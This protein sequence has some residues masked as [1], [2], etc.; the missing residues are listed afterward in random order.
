MSPRNQS[1]VIKLKVNLYDTD[2]EIKGEMSLPAVFD[3]QLRQDLIRKAFRAITL[4][5]LGVY[6]LEENLCSSG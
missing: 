1:R 2:G 4:S 6:A 5:L 3:T